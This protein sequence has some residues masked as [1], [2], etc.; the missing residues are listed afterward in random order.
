M[1]KIRCHLLVAVSG[2]V[3]LAIA[4]LSPAFTRSVSLAAPTVS[5]N[6]D[7]TEAEVI[8]QS[9]TN[10]VNTSSLIEEF[11][12]LIKDF[13]V[14]HQSREV[15]LNISIRYRLKPGISDAEYPDYEPIIR[16]VKDFLTNYPNEVDY[17]EII[18]KKLTQMVLEKNQVIS[19]ITIELEMP[20]SHAGSYSHSSIVTRDRLSLSKPARRKG[21]R[22]R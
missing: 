6:G 18:N 22:M 7:R 19:S 13:K 14:A 12:I 5:T 16:G 8:R 2:V 3:L 21:N 10:I 1:R 11:T 20:S 4:H 9:S 15:A 17:W